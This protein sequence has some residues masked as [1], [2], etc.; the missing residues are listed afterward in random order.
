M[1][2]NQLN[3]HHQEDNLI[4]EIMMSASRAIGYMGDDYQVFCIGNFPL[5]FE[6]YRQDSKRGFLNLYWFIFYFK[7]EV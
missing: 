4:I 1:D 3:F 6:A 2:E 7:G 5:T